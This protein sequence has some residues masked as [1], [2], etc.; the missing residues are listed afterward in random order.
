M[1]VTDATARPVDSLLACY[2][3][4]SLS[5]AMHALVASHLMLS[6]DS[7]G[8]VSALESALGESLASEMAQPV[9]DRDAR[10][11]AIFDAPEAVAAAPPECGI[12]PPPLR[13]LVGLD[14]AALKWRTKLPGIKE[15]RISA[16]GEGEA[17]LLWIKAGRKIPF[18]THGGSEVTLVLQGAFRDAAGH[19]ARG[20]LAIA[21]G[22]VNHQPVVDAD[23]DCIC[24]A[25]TDAPLR[26]TGPVGRIVERLFGHSH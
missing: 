21:D 14:F 20:D 13:S 19:Y 26:M 18:H 3:A 8:F 4:G 11:A 9:P 15:C 22:S 16:E 23:A 7:A 2:C 5:P 10:L 1:E 6:S 17:N 25:V 24:F 12:L